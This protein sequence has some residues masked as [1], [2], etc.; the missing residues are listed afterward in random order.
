METRQKTEPTAKNP[1]KRNKW[2]KRGQ[3]NK[4]ATVKRQLIREIQ[5]KRDIS[6]KQ[7]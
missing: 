5:E 2:R 6:I 1:Q 4:L 3:A 7:I